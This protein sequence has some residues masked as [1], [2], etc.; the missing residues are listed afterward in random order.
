MRI[1]LFIGTLVLLCVPGTEV[2]TFAI[3]TLGILNE[4]VDLRHVDDKTYR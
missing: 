4:R 1:L 3:V 2:F